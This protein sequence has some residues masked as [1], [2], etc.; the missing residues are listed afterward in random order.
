MGKYIGE[1]PQ[2]KVY[3]PSVFPQSKTCTFC[4]QSITSRVYGGMHSH[5]GI[6]SIN[7]TETYSPTASTIPN[8]RTQTH[9]GMTISRASIV[10]G[11]RGGIIIFDASVLSCHATRSRNMSS[12]TWSGL[13]QTGPCW[14]LTCFC[15]LLRD[16]LK[17]S[18]SDRSLLV[19]DG[20]IGI[21]YMWQDKDHSGYTIIGIIVARQW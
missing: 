2:Q 7:S 14:C 17:W 9:G 20:L 12:T 5:L 1:M 15:F 18:E 21:K 13:N 4:I 16:N 19:L 6:K 3:S 11:V 10:W 8:P